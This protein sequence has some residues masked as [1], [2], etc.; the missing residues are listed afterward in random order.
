M[1]DRWPTVGLAAAVVIAALALDETA[2]ADKNNRYSVRGLGTTTCGKYLEMRNLNVD[3]SDQYANWLTG[4][5]TAYNWLKPETYDIAP[6]SQFDKT[7]LLRFIDI[8]CGTYPTKRVIDA[9]A[10]FVNQVYDK[11]VK[12]GS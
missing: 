4:F 10:S 6:A 7:H 8:Y 2:A 9:A 1:L 12:V 5:L 11:R 3:E